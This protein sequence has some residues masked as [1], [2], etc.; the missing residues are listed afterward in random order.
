MLKLY[1]TRNPNIKMN[2]NKSVPLESDP[3]WASYV[4]TM[5]L[6]GKVFRFSTDFHKNVKLEEI[7][8]THRKLKVCSYFLPWAE[9]L[10]NL[11]HPR[12][13]VEA[14][15]AFGVGLLWANYI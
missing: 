12:L 3:E 9:Y 6:S 10:S 15:L 8:K 5:S 14:L 11:P 2:K 13:Y 7:Q 4:N 1:I